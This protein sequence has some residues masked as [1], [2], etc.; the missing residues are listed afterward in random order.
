MYVPC[1]DRGRGRA[2]IIAH[3]R[4]C[5]RTS[6]HSGAKCRRRRHG[7]FWGCPGCHQRGPQIHKWH[8]LEV[9]RSSRPSA[10]RLE[11]RHKRFPLNELHS[12]RRLG[13]KNRQF[14]MEPRTNLP[15]AL[16][17]R[18]SGPATGSRWVQDRLTPGKMAARLEI[19][20]VRP[21]SRPPGRSPRR[22]TVFC[23]VLSSSAPRSE[24]HHA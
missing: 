8:W 14:P 17:D 18:C 9:P 13:E 5:L 24:G 21:A 11:P 10:T 20:V 7:R 23:S 4:N 2:S 3:R 16:S 22:A 12:P 1:S 19:G 15:K 6:R